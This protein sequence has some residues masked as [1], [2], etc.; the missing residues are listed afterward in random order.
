MAVSIPRTVLAY[1]N[2]KIMAL[3]NI[4][5]EVSIPRTVLAYLNDTR[6]V[7]KHHNEKSQSRERS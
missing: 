3:G 1:L 6:E 5:E 4:G 7:I 2:V